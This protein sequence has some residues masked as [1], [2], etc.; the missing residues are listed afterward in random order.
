MSWRWQPDLSASL[1]QPQQSAIPGGAPGARRCSGFPPG[2]GAAAE[3]P[4]SRC[5]YRR[6][7]TLRS[8]C[9]HSIFHLLKPPDDLC[10]IVR[11]LIVTADSKKLFRWILFWACSRCLVPLHCAF[12]AV[13]W[14]DWLLSCE[15]LLA[16]ATFPAIPAAVTHSCCSPD[17][18]PPVMLL[19]PY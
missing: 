11:P 5:G 1:L 2:E 8:V 16:A 15:L 3:G 10:S 6:W 13:D 19:W 18:W 14:T 4:P 9:S 12:D 17:L 7:P